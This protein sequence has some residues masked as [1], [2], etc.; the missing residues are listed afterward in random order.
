MLDPAH[1]EKTSPDLF[2]VC[3]RI[4]LLGFGPNRASE[5]HGDFSR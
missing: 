2:T 4:F 3:I 1:R 5:Y